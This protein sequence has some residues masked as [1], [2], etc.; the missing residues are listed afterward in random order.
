[1]TATQ[2]NLPVKNRP[3]LNLLLGILFLLFFGSTL[4]YKATVIPPEPDDQVAEK[5]PAGL[6]YESERASGWSKVRASYIRRHPVCEACATVKDLNVHHIKPFSKY[7]ELE[8]DTTNLI[9]LCRYH[10]F[11]IGHKGNWKKYNPNCRQDA[12]KLFE[13]RL[14]VGL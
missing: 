10:H 13:S 14:A 12:K 11:W 2:E 6:V 5:V 4:A 7:P 8:L 3:W 9:T 1:M